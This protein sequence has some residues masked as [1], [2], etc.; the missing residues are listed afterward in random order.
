MLE[1]VKRVARVARAFLRGAGSTLLLVL[2]NRA[3]YCSLQ[4]RCL[5]VLHFLGAQGKHFPSF[6]RLVLVSLVRSLKVQAILGRTSLAESFLWHSVRCEGGA[7]VVKLRR[8]VLR[9]V[10]R[11]VWTGFGGLSLLD[12]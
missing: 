6:H 11:V 3:H 10:E 1:L 8:E 5:L 2:L 7:L 12:V 9:K 4:A